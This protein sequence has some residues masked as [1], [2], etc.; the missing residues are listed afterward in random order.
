MPKVVPGIL[1]VDVVWATGTAG[2]LIH[3]YGKWKR[4]QASLKASRNEGRMASPDKEAAMA[5]RPDGLR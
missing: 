5:S 4:V 1:A 2:H 3:R